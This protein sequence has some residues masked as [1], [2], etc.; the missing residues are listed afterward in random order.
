LS[1]YP[2]I[3]A[4]AYKSGQQDEEREPKHSVPAIIAKRALFEARFPSCI[5]AAN[6]PAGTVA[7]VATV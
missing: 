6:Q 1:N 4:K 5:A 3:N 2:Q 7:Y